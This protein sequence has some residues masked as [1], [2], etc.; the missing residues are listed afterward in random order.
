MKTLSKN[1]FNLGVI[2]SSLMMSGCINLNAKPGS[3]KAGK[4]SDAQTSA[5]STSQYFEYNSATENQTELCPASPNVVPYY[6]FD[7]DGTNH[8]SVCR[9]KGGTDASNGKYSI[10]G[11]PS[12]AATSRV[13]CAVPIFYVDE[14]VLHQFKTQPSLAVKPYHYFSNTSQ[15]DDDIT[16][17]PVYCDDASDS[18][19][20]VFFTG[21]EFNY[22]MV[23]EKRYET[24]IRTCLV[25]G[26]F[27]SCSR[28]AFG[29]IR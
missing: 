6:D 12:K 25:T 13:V 17:V 2:I 18:L 24:Q 28:Y 19:A 20:E 21:V 26:N 29:A 8:Y 15:Y 14:E 1:L 5:A 10:H 7:F 3:I 4:N 16:N 22:M 9:A 11:T 23:F 27:A